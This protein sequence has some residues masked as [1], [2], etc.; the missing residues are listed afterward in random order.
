MGH[1]NLAQM[2]STC[3][4]DLHGVAVNQEYPTVV[5]N[6]YVSLIDIAKHMTMVMNDLESRCGVTRC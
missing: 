3:G 4:I 6:H 2:D 1:T 5:A